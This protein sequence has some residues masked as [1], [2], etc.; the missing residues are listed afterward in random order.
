MAIYGN[1][2]DTG[3]ALGTGGLR[4][5]AGAVSVLAGAIAFAFSFDWI[6]AKLPIAA[7]GSVRLPGLPA[8]RTSP[9]S[10][11]LPSSALPR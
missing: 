8:F 3:F 4:V 7:L 5:L 11:G 1:H 9:S 2:P 6:K 10:L